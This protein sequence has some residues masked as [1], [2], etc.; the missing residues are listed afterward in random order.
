MSELT[1]AARPYARAVFEIAR[2]SESFD[3]WSNR[4]QFLAAVVK[5]PAMMRLL[6]APKLTHQERASMVESVSADHLD[7]KGSNF[8]KTL[9][10]NGRLEL[11]PDIAAI[12]EEYRA[13]SEGSIEA[14]VTSATELDEEQTRKIAEAL[15]KRLQREVRIVSSVDPALIS[16]AIIRAG[17]LVI[18]G[19]VRGRLQNLTQAIAG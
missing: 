2:E 12:F 7:E 1:T 4:L 5:D 11:L 6:D 8:V 18:D 17:D 19:S 13:D 15:S 16:G 9:A 10:E 14:R 3:T